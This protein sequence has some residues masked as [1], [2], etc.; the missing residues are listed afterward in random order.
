MDIKKTFGIALSAAALISFAV[1]DSDASRR[2]EKCYGVVKAGQNDCKTNTASCA[3]T[4]EKDG[5]P[6]AFVYLPKGTC[7]KIVGGVVKSR[8][9]RR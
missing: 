2:T 7:E 1:E 8:P 5:Q 9:Y 3:G 6:D 4:S